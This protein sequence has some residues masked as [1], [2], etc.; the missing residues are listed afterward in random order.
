[1]PSVRLHPDSNAGVRVTEFFPRLAANLDGFSVVRDTEVRFVRVANF[2]GR[3]REA[4]GNCISGT[5]GKYLQD[6][7]QQEHYHEPDGTTPASRF[8]PLA[9]PC[10]SFYHGVRGGAAPDGLT[11][12]ALRMRPV[13]S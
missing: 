1:V 2:H 11:L 8:F 4:N 12:A 3:C 9:L 7:Q 6:R 10:P 13:R 5:K